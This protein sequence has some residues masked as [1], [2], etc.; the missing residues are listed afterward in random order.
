MC[1]TSGM[2]VLLPLDIPPHR[3]AATGCC[4]G[5]FVFPRNRL[6]MD[7][8]SNYSIHHLRAG[9]K[10]ARY[11]RRQALNNPRLRPRVAD[12]CSSAFGNCSE[13]EGMS[14][15]NYSIHHLRAACKGARYFRRQA[16]NNP[17]PYKQVVDYCS[18]A[19]GNCSELE[20]MSSTNYPIHHLRL[21]CKGA[22][23]S[24]RQAL[25]TLRHHGQG[26][27]LCNSAFG[28]CSGV[29]GMSSTNYS[30]R[31]LREA[32]TGV[33]PPLTVELQCCVRQE[34]DLD[35]RHT[36]LRL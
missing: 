35:L 17:R 29:E 27:D 18:S 1:H 12:C 13:L 20:G 15:T 2:A 32:T 28:Y 26:A 9:C 16:L 6:E 7:T 33:H 22:N 5:D 31:R 19:F 11:F 21:G 25:N 34:T 8:C 23:Y 4:I 24:H 14:S 30:I 3:T 10:G 36:D